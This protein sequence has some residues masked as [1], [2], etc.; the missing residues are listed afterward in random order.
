LKLSIHR[1]FKKPKNTHCSPN[2]TL[3]ILRKRSLLPRHHQSSRLQKAR[4]L[5]NVADHPLQPRKSQLPKLPLRKNRAR[6]VPRR[7]PLLPRRPK[8]ASVV[9][10]P[11][12]S[13]QLSLKNRMKTMQRSSQSKLSRLTTTLMKKCKKKRPIVVTFMSKIYCTSQTTRN[14]GSNTRSSSPSTTRT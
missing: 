10:N 3:S 4:P 9:P 13:S 7:T 11:R 2:S 12:I 8:E 5:A 14:T 1:K 6:A